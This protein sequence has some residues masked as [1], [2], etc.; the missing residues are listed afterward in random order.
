MEEIIIRG[1]SVEFNGKKREF[2]S[3]SAARS[4]ARWLLH[5]RQW[6]HGNGWHGAEIINIDPDTD[7]RNI[8]ADCLNELSAQFKLEKWG[9]GRMAV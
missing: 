2:S 5:Y 1:C 7:N 9:C 4:E 3:E 8:V 6:N